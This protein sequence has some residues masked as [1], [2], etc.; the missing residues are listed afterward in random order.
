[1]RFVDSGKQQ[2]RLVCG[3]ERFT[4][5]GSDACVQ[6]T[7]FADVPQDARVV[8]EEIVGPVLTIQTADLAGVGR[9]ERELSIR[10]QC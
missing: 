8:R 9:P 1:M 10:Q 2:A 3:G 7:I 5:S 4:P 6:P